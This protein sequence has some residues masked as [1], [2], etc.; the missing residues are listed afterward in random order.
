[1]KIT[2]V[3]LF[4][5]LSLPALA[6][7]PNIVLLFADDLGYG[8]LACYGHPYAET[9]NLDKLAEGGTMFTQFHVTGNWCNPSRTGLLTSRHHATM[10][11]VSANTGFAWRKTVTQ[12]FK[13]AG[14]VTGH[15]GKWHLG[16]EKSPGTYG[17]DEIK[18]LGRHGDIPQGRDYIMYDA[19][20]DFIER[21]KD[22]PF[23][24][25]VMGFVPHYP[26][27][28]SPQ[29]AAR[30]E[31]VAVD[32]SLFGRQMNSQFDDCVAIG[33]DI[34]EGMRNYLGEIYGLDYQVGRL[35]SKL[36]ELGLREN[37]IVIFSSDNG[38]AGV[39][40][41]NHPTDP[42][43]EENPSRNMLGSSEDLRGQKHVDY[44]G[45]VRVPFIISWPGS[46]PGG[47]V[48]RTS[49]I[50]ALDYL[51]TVCS[52]A[53]VSYDAS[54]YEG[55]DISDIW[56]G[57]SRSRKNPVFQNN[58]GWDKPSSILQGNWKLHLNPD[59]SIELYDLSTEEHE[60]RNVAKQFPEIAQSLERQL[61]KWNTTRPRKYNRNVDQMLPDPE[62]KPVVTGP[63]SSLP[64]DLN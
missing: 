10:P 37:T 60:F 15:F 48:N 34:N 61:N 43:L 32:R 14:Y 5:V 40:A 29:L 9:P 52:L 49:V 56:L 57:A 23:Y 44:E 8:D 11:N 62:V 47:R 12:L 2:S 46:I 1:M 22:E 16:P 24:V 38:P 41:G 54:W 18:E 19:A 7:N 45:G 28:P 25:N 4:L 39:L 21:H 33:G 58:N 42:A 17:M 63:V 27:N 59:G 13:E 36:D 35:L 64:V 20:M 53:G 6:R 55:E 31:H 3:F 51:P 26:V 50:S 30:F